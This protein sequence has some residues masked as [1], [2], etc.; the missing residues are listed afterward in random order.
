MY[1][2]KCIYVHKNTALFR[3]NYTKL[4]FD[5]KHLERS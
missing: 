5:A 4:Y 2:C 3:E 1:I